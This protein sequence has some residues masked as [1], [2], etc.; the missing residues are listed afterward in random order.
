MRKL[1]LLIVFCV[2]ILMAAIGQQVIDGVYQGSPTS[3]MYLPTEPP[4]GGWENSWVKPSYEGSGSGSVFNFT[5]HMGVDTGENYTHRFIIRGAD[6]TVSP[7]DDYC[8]RHRVGGQYYNN[9]VLAEAWNSGQYAGTFVDT[10]IQMGKKGSWGD[11]PSGCFA[12]QIIYSFVPDTVNPMLLLNFAFVTEDGQHSYVSNPAVEFSVLN[13]SNDYANNDSY[14]DLG[15]YD[16]THPYSRYWYRTPTGSSHYPEDPENTPVNTVPQFL[17][18]TDNC[19]TQNAGRPVA[20]YPYTVLAYDL[21]TQAMDHQ[22]VDFRV[23]VNSCTSRF[24]WAYCYFTAKMVPVTLQMQ[25]CGGDTLILD[26]PWGFDKNSEVSYKW[27]NGIDADNCTRFYPDDPSNSSNPRIFEGTN[28]YHLLLYPDPTKPYYR[29]EVQSN[30]GIPFTYE[31]TI[32]YNVF[33]PSFTVESE[34]LDQSIVSANSIIVHNTSQIGFIRPHDTGGVD[35]IWQNMEAYS[36]YCVWD[37]G[38]GSPVV[39]G[40][41][42]THVYADPGSYTISLHIADNEMICG[43]YEVDTTIIVQSLHSSISD[44]LSDELVSIYPNPTTGNVSL[45][46]SGLN[47]KTVELFSMN[48]QL[49]NTVVPTTETMTMSLSQYANGIYFVRIH[50]DNGIT[51]QKIV[52]K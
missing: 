25:Y 3:F 15:N 10:V 42:P 45:D 22:A 26:V 39:Y 44:F 2:S 40:F 49:L 52:K 28:K 37:F 31:K 46:L 32:N 20:T 47:A 14:L 50:S 5:N 34:A 41:E 23:R 35:T 24:H 38:D 51:T 8:F 43:F 30:T 13:H 1:L 12:Q 33:K 36:D 6:P 9:P 48:G 16:A 18:V 4:A 21:S 19:P 7:E 29:C 27:Y 11:A 17:A